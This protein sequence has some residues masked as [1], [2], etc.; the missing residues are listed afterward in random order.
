MRNVVSGLAWALPLLA[1]STVFCRAEA[2]APNCGQAKVEQVQGGPP[3]PGPSTNYIVPRGNVGPFYQWESNNGYCGEAS[4]MQAGLANGQWISQYNTRLLCG[5]FFGPQTNGYGAS[6]KQAGNPPS[7]FGNYNAQVLLQT[8][9]QNLSGPNDFGFA[10]RCAANA[11]LNINVYPANTGNTVPNDGLAGYRDYMSWI[12]SQVIAGKQVTIGVLLKGEDDAQYEHIVTVMKIGTNHSA[13]DATYYGDDVLY[14]DDHGLYTLKLVNGQWT[15]APNPSKPLGAGSDTTGCT[16]YIYAYTFDSLGK[17]R[18][19]A[20]ASNASAYSIIIPGATKSV[21]TVAGN[22]ASDGQGLAKVYGRHNFGFAVS[23]PN[24]TQGVTKPISL[25]ILGTET[26]T[27]GVWQAN[28]LDA[29]STPNAGYNYE[30]P[31]IGGPVGSCDTANCVSN[32]QPPAM[33]MTLQ[34]TVSGLTAGTS[35]NLYEYDFP[36]LTGADTGTAAALPVPTSGF[37]ANS[38]MATSV[39]TFTAQGPTYTTVP[40]TRMSDQIVIFRAVPTSAP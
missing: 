39:A 18:T 8:P 17:S 21:W 2:S 25:K 38:S 22:T 36:T 23:G 28:P 24:D 20:N 33:R 3:P 16:P 37:N 1:A 19:A 11:R 10:A 6:L 34:A 30:H 14:F 15:S 40:L 29:N 9:N 26:L 7:G 4:L 31:Y 5:A 27:N 13:T 32:T 35:Y 12:K